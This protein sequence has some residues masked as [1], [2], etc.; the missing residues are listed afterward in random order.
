MSTLKEGWYEVYQERHITNKS[1]GIRIVSADPK[2]LP[3]LEGDIKFLSGTAKNSVWE[4][5]PGKTGIFH[6]PAVTNRYP[7]VS[8]VSLMD[9]WNREEE[10]FGQILQM[11]ANAITKLY[12]YGNGQVELSLH[13][14]GVKTDTKDLYRGDLKSWPT[15]KVKN[16]GIELISPLDT[17]E[18]Y[19]RWRSISG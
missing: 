8:C 14:N 16:G 18:L 7:V 9:R 10:H 3:G 17:V 15:I 4:Y 19:K 11:H 5:M 6:Y 13:V 2:P 12:N 1:R